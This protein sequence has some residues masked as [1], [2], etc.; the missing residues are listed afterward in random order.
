V[1]GLGDPRTI[2]DLVPQVLGAVLRRFGDF[3]AAEDA[4][5]E[6]LEAASVQWP[7]QGVPSNPGGWLTRVAGRRMIDHIRQESARRRREAQWTRQGDSSWFDKDHWFDEDEP[8]P[9]DPLLL[10]FLCCPP[11]LAP[12]AAIPLTLRAVGGLTTAQ[13]A[14]ALLVPEATVAQRIL[15]AKQK[16]REGGVPFSPPSEAE[17][18]L[19]LNC[20]LQ[21]LYL[22]F[23]EGYAGGGPQL[24]RNDLTAEAIRLTRLALGSLPDDAETAGLLAL[25]LL[26]QARAPARID[27]AGNLVPLLDQDRSHWDPRLMAE[28]EALLTKTLGRGRV[29]VYQLQAAIAAVHGTAVTAAQTDWAQILTLYGLLMSLTDNPMVRLNHAVAA[30]MVHGPHEGLRL[31]A[32]LDSIPALTGHFR[33]DAVRGF[34]WEKAGNPGVAAG[35][36]QSASEKTPSLP[37]RDHLRLQAARAQKMGS[38]QDSPSILVMG[39]PD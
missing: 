16:I 2:A 25:M 37:E 14:R 9:D 28:G 29:G 7:A 15:R 4:V 38:P 8:H 33:L 39:R 26:T 10:L 20:V 13:I 18:A 17:K 27:P 32:L 11:G 21:V 36:Y 23:N 30:A 22:M 34:L 19:R 5:Q 35:F 12:S 24:Q 6:A 31:V 3:P 1:E